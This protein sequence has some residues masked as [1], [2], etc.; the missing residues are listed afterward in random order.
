MHVY[1]KFPIVD[2][3]VFIAVSINGPIAGIEYTLQALFICSVIRNTSVN[4]CMMLISL[5]HTN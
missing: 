4:G 1:G 2:K 5:L 3:L